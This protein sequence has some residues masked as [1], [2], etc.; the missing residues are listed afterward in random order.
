MPGPCEPVGSLRRSSDCAQEKQEVAGS[1]A[2]RFRIICK[3]D[4]YSLFLT[5][6]K[7]LAAGETNH[8]KSAEETGGGTALSGR[9]DA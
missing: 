2:E 7:P 9:S 8:E 1:E 5:A 3:D 4:Q 6:E